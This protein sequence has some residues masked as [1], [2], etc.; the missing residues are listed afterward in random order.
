M[1][2]SRVSEKLRFGFKEKLEKS[3]KLDCQNQGAQTLLAIQ[4]RDDEYI[5]IVGFAT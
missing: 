2:T 4:P 1:A 5:Q 3:K